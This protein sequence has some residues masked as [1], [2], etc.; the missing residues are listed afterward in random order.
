MQRLRGHLTFANTISCVALFVALSGGA[1]AYSALP[2]NSVGNA[3]IRTGAVRSSEIHDRS[4]ALKDISLSARGSLRGKTG[5]AGPQG[6]A[7]P[8]GPA[9]VTYKAAISAGGGVIRGGFSVGTSH[10]TN[11]SGDYTITFGNRDLS[12]CVPTATVGTTDG[13][14]PGGGWASIT[15]AG[16]GNLIVHTR[17]AAGSPVDLPF[18]L[19]VAC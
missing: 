3:Q 5:S 14:V 12:A 16:G 19:I 18:F 10:T 2:R 13:S 15:D 7:G 8:A 9:A 1:Y 6:P 17:N 4:V 11:G